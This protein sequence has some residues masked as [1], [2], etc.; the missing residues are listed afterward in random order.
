MTDTATVID[1]P[2]N[3]AG[4]FALQPIEGQ[5]S[6]PQTVATFT[7]PGGPEGLSDYS[8]AIAWGDGSASPGVISV[9]ATGHFT[10]KGNHA[11]AEES[12][13][14]HPG[15]APYNIAITIRH[16]N[17]TPQ[18]VADAATVSDPHVVVAAAP[19]PT[20]IAG[21]NTGPVVLATFTD[22]GGAETL[23]DYSA[24]VNW[25]DGSPTAVNGGTIA[26]A[27]GVFTVTAAHTYAAPGNNV[28]T[29]TIH[30]ETSA[31]QSVTLVAAVK[32]KLAIVLLDP[33]GKAA[34]DVDGNASVKVNG[35]AAT[36]DVNSTSSDAAD[37]S[38]NGSVSAANINVT[39]G[40][41]T[42]GHGTFSAPVTH[43]PP[44][45]D[46]INLPLPPAPSPTF[47]PAI[48]AGNTAVTLKPGTY[49]GGIHASG[50]A[51]VTLLPGIYYL[52][53]GGFTVDGGASVTGVGVMIVNDPFFFFGPISLSGQAKVTISAPTTLT[54]A[55]AAYNGIALFEDRSS[56]APISISGQ[57][58]MILTG[59][60]Y[61]AGA[62][63]DL[64]GQGSLTI[65]ASPS[66]AAL[67][68]SDLDA[69]GNSSLVIN[70]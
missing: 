30:H 38:G 62:A 4:G 1:S 21:V 26:F 44:V 64:D 29:V 27:G 7:D 11:Y 39:G 34:L 33:R 32:P 70:D 41:H 66:L 54:G 31:A 40:T 35:A 52:K 48:V 50:H 53:G 59:S 56:A 6:G 47:G 14:D 46:P 61:A 49:V 45:A 2:V 63:L 12:A 36:I 13:A 37:V 18:T 42:S 28:I 5:D 10:V 22:P 9:D 17:T 3:A 65:N 23:G 20:P 19:N 57:A 67:V 68:L 24:D 25:G 43:K 15:S 60:L 8:A 55:L 51:Q 69:S 16:E 58:S